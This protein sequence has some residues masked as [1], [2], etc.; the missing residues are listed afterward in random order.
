MH[1]A[2]LRLV[3][4]QEPAKWDSKRH[5]FAAAAEAMRRILVDSA[6]RRQ[7]QKRGGQG[8]REPLGD[9]EVSAPVPADDLL[10]I[11]EA[12]R[13]LEQTDEAAAQ[14]VKLRYFSGLTVEEAAGILGVSE[15]TARR[16]WVYARAWLYREMGREPP[17]E[18]AGAAHA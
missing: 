5:F 14:F 1:E 4:G 10:A 17:E 8:R 18:E 15:R 12:L 3:D 7:T 2:W 11:D 9:V 13:K 16:T 6:R